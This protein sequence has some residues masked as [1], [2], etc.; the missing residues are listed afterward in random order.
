MIAAPSPNPPGECAPK[1]LLA[2]PPS[3][4]LLSQPSVPKSPIRTI[5]VVPT[6]PPT[7]WAMM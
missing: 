2:K 1:P 5:K 3:C 7:I 4:A 6:A